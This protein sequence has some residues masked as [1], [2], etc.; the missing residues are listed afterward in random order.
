MTKILT[1]LLIG[2]VMSCSLVFA[3]DNLW[4]T[5]KNGQHRVEFALHGQTSCV[6]V[7]DRIFCARA[8]AR[9]PIKP[10]SMALR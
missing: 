1:S 3:Q 9:A 7:N 4:V 8:V 2:A 5:S 10:T 6:M